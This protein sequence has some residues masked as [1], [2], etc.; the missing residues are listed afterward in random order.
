M[1]NNTQTAK[2]NN[3]EFVSKTSDE[4]EVGRTL[5]LTTPKQDSNEF[6]CECGFTNEDD[7]SKWAHLFTRPSC[8]AAYKLSHPPASRPPNR[9][10]INTRRAGKAI[11]AIAA[12]L[13][14]FAGLKARHISDEDDTVAISDTYRHG[15]AGNEYRSGDS[16]LPDRTSGNEDLVP[17]RLAAIRCVEVSGVA[18]L[19][20]AGLFAKFLLLPMTEQ[21]RSLSNTTKEK[22]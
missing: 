9:R 15:L 18:V 17:R 8:Y 2:L 16:T 22:D 20:T 11:I 19:I 5:K 3:Q 4:I 13:L 7:A 1:D 6:V 14:V 12:T 10:G 21:L